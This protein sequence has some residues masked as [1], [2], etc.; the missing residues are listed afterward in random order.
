[1]NLGHE[2]S[3]GDNK[4]A[5]LISFLITGGFMII[6]AIGGWLTNSLALLSDAGHMLSDTVSLGI[7]V[8]AF[9]IGE[10]AAD[11][12]KTYGYKRFE[13][14]AALFNGITLAVVSIYIFYEAIRR[15]GSPP[16]I[17]STGM[18]IIA[19]IG[20]IVNITVAF[21][22]HSGGDTHGNLN[23][24]AAFLHVIGDLLGS[25]G[26]IIAAV[27]IKL[28]GWSLADPIASVIV[29]IL[30]LVSAWRVLRDSLQVLMEGVPRDVEVD[31]VIKTI[32][33]VPGVIDLHHLHIWAITDEQ[34]ALSCHLVIDGDKKIEEGDKILRQV[35]QVLAEKHIEHVTI[36][37]ESEH[38]HIDANVI[39][40]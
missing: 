2:H 7:G 29:A 27:L 3:H 13:I 33:E 8:A 9:K 6:E 35:E 23:L 15:F 1:M 12:S 28:F 40:E 14:L 22:M 39:S 32:R 37:F 16:E 31:S 20:L 25:V 26:A 10:K 17:S 18:L 4:K 21:I 5:L 11:H 34:R 36:Q 19:V 38:Q 30:V 24:R